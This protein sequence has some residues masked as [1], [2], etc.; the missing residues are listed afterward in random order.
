MNLVKPVFTEYE[1]QVLHEIA[2]HRLQPN[3]IQRILD[4]LGKPVGKLFQ[5]ARESKLPALKGIND[6]VQGWVQ[7]ALSRACR[8][9]T[10]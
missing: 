7:E 2:L 8:R 10:A 9:Q 4:T 6:R 1:R 5:I 3:S